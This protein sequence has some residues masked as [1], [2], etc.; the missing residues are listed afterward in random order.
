MTKLTTRFCGLRSKT[1]FQNSKRNLKP[2][3]NSKMSGYA[4]ASTTNT[5]QIHPNHLSHNL[6]IT[7]SLIS[8]V[9]NTVVPSL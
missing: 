5:Y 6:S 9:P 7:A 8:F 1:I 4:D 2:H 3:L